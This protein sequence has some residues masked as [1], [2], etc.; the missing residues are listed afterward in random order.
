MNPC[1]D[2]NERHATCHAH[3]VKYSEWNEEHTRQRNA[4]NVR[5][6]GYRWTL[7]KEQYLLSYRVKGR[8]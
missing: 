4:L 1:Y 8:V 7:G 5:K 6:H 2:C 3:C